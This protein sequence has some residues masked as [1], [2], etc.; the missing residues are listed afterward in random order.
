M[1]QIGPGGIMQNL[2]LHNELEKAGVESACT[3]IGLSF[4]ELFCCSTVEGNPY[5]A[6]TWIVKENADFLVINAVPAVSDQNRLFWEEWYLHKGEIHHHVLSLWRPHTYHAVFQ[7][8]S[9]DDIHPAPCF[10]S[11][12]YVIEDPDM[13][14]WLLRR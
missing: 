12:W 1:E 6:H 2:H 3:R 13:T 8:P 9:Q 5:H 7:A 10:G 4:N 11:A 14:P